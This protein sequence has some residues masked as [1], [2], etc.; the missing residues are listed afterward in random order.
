MSGR[1]TDPED[2]RP[3]LSPVPMR[4]ITARLVAR[5]ERPVIQAML[6]YGQVGCGLAG[7]CETVT[8]AARAYAKSMDRSNERDIVT[9][10]LPTSSTVWTVRCCTTR[11]W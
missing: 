2:A 5:Q 1:K 8:H 3:I 7:A 9:V 10:D 4:K 11:W 6:G